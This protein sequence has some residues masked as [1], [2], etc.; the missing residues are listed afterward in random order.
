MNQPECGAETGNKKTKIIL[1]LVRLCSLAS[2]IANRHHSRQAFIFSLSGN[3]VITGKHRHIVYHLQERS[4][5]HHHSSCAYVN[6]ENGLY[7]PIAKQGNYSTFGNV[8]SSINLPS[9]IVKY[10]PCRRMDNTLII[11]LPD[12]RVF[13]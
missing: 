5:D 8:F 13:S 1:L 6:C 10:P 4:P 7:Q 2:T 3:L 11:R 12:K 9:R